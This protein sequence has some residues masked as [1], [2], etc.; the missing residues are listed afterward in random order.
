MVDKIII[1]ESPGLLKVTKELLDSNREVVKQ[2]TESNK[3]S[4]AKSFADNAAEI[5]SDQLGQKRDAK[6]DKDAQKLSQKMAAN[7]RNLD[8]TAK[9]IKYDSLGKAQKPAPGDT[10]FG[11]DAKIERENVAYRAETLQAMEK[12]AT[13]AEDEAK[14]KKKEREE[15]NAKKEKTSDEFLQKE[16]INQSFLFSI[17][18]GFTGIKS[19][20]TVLANIENSKAKLKD[21]FSF[22]KFK[23][24]LPKIMKSTEFFK[25]RNFKAI[26]GTLLGKSFNIYK[27][28]SKKNSMAVL[29]G[30]KSGFNTLKSALG[31]VFGPFKRILQAIGAVLLVGG[32]FTFFNSK[33]WKDMKPNIAKFIGEALQKTEKALTFL[34]SFLTD[35]LNPAINMFFRAI[36]AVTDF[37]IEYLIPGMDKGNEMRKGY[38][39]KAREKLGP[40]ATDAMIKAEADAQIEIARKRHVDQKVEQIQRTYAFNNRGKYGAA[41]KV[42]TKDMIENARKQFDDDFMFDLD[43]GIRSKANS[44]SIYKNVVAGTNKYQY[45]GTPGSD[46]SIISNITNVTNSKQGDS[47]V[48]NNN[49]LTSNNFISKLYLQP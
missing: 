27:V 44:D 9:G 43:G 3:S 30:I 5:L 2:V 37:F 42:M 11:Q 41:D 20:V 4:L 33:M 46:G 32:L 24:L 31:G 47:Y 34:G 35:N 8:T 18:Q 26:V 23:T 28:F 6:R 16:I 21:M 45:S 13:F 25:N 22:S 12:Q 40:G 17:A 19:A 1:Q 38:M 39:S 10:S 36:K 29:K 7:V 14:R 15:T 49:A 48:S